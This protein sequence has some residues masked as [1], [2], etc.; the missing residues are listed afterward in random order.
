MARYDE[1]ESRWLLPTFMRSDAFDDAM[2]AIVDELGGDASGSTRAYSVWDA[3]DD[4]DE[5]AIDALADELNILWYDRLATLES[6]RNVVKN[7]KRIQAKLGTKWALEEVLNLYYSGNTVVTEWFDYARARGEPNH[8]MIE[9]EYTASTDAETRRFMSILNKI[10]RKSAVLDRV[11]AVISSTATPQACAWAHHV[12]RE[13]NDVIDDGSY[14]VE[15]IHTEWRGHAY[16]Q[17]RRVEEIGV[18]R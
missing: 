6:K 5:D 4:L 3:I 2:A 11:Y 1:M 16:L 13:E 14:A 18:R 10:K 8:F 15:V 9:T 17:G 7:C 12:R